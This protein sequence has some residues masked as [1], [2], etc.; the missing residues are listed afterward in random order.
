MRPDRPDFIVVGSGLA[1]LSFAAL[2]ARRGRAVRVIEAHEHAG[3]FAHTFEA[4]GFRFNA[5]LHYVWNCGEGQT[6]NRFLSKLGLV[7]DVRFVRYDPLGFD[8]MRMPGYAL[9]IPGDPALLKSRL[10]ALFP[11]ERARLE[12]F[13]DE[14]F[15]T[16]D[17][18][19]RVPTPVTPR[20]LLRAGR[21]RRVI[22]YRG[23]SLQDVFDRFDLP[24]PAQTLLALQW[25]DF[26]LP[27]A[28]LSFFAWV[29]L[30]VGYCRGAYYPERHFEHVIDTLV[31]TIKQAGGEVIL[32]QRVID[33]LFAGDRM[34]GVRAEV[35]DKRGIAEDLRVDHF[36]GAVVCNM[37][38][39]AAAA[40]I[41]PE[42]FSAKLRRR[43][44]YTYSP[45]NFVAYLGVEGI[46]LRDYGFGRSNLFHTEEPDLNR[47]FMQMERFGDYRRPSFALTTPSLLTDD[48]SDRPPGTQI[49]ELL[50]VADFARFAHLR[51]ANIKAY[52]AKKRE[53]FASILRIIERDYVP[54]F[55]DR[56]CFKMLGSPTTNLRYCLAPEG[57]S[58][59]SDM[60][61]AS[62][63]PGR[64]DHRSS[65][66]G[67]YFCNAS[68]GYAGFAGTVWTGSRLYEELTGDRFL[69]HGH[70]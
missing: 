25:P 48:A 41:G 54:G 6:V 33:F 63:G 24:L 38:P 39:R 3:G 66:P 42:R 26:L 60:S 23:A 36:G 5:Q 17:E 37:D 13:V 8:R 47:A 2:M 32:G 15:A 49:V 51:S 7:D 50:T 55:G 11:G 69:D 1:A 20:D 57:N 65:I 22:R 27:P 62:V 44:D 4:A 56:I 67:L 46:D 12:A 53:I 52:N 19:D 10:A 29:M 58:Y 28:R 68:A 34:V 16:A 40:I 70:G 21:F 18:L 45:S 61:P 9:D 59:G 30:F 35:V 31:A 43:L 14:V 64:L